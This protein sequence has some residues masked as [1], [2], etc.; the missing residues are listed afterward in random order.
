ML[1]VNVRGVHAQRA[2][3]ENRDARQ[4]AG[5]GQFVQHIDNLLRAPDGK[6]GDDDFAVLLE[7][8][9][10]EFADQIVRVRA[11]L[12][13]AR[14][15]GGF[16]LEII[17]VLDGNRVAQQFI[18]AA[19]D[20]AGEQLAEFSA[21]FLNVQNHLRRTENVSGVAE[22]DGHAGHGLKRIFRNRGRRVAARI[23]GR[24]AWCKAARPAADVFSRALWKRTSRPV[25]EC[26]PSP[27]A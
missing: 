19:P 8:F 10:D 4:F 18:A 25:P 6:R 21:V 11:L 7:R 20:V 23:S 15:V 9:A 12:V 26:A 16:D 13:D 1:V 14:G 3:H 22:R 17:H 5:A 27:A 24:R 2:V